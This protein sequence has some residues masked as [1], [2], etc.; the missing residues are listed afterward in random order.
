LN[1][2]KYIKWFVKEN[3]ITLEDGFPITCYR[4]DY[5]IDEDVFHEWA[6]HIRRHYESDDDLKESL[7]E[8]KMS[9]ENYLRSLVIPQ[10]SDLLG[11]TSRS[12]D[13]TEIMISDLIEFIHGY[14]VPRCKQYN[15]SGKTQS[16]HG[17]DILAYK[18]LNPDNIPSVK[19]ELLVI[20]VKSEL[21]SDKY[22]PIKDAVTISHK[23]DKIR[24]TH[25]LNYYRKKLRYLKKEKQA[26]EISRFQNK[27]EHDYLIT[28]IA[29][30]INS[31]ITIPENIIFGI[32]GDDLELRNND[33][34][35]LVHG[36]KLMD[37]AHAIYDRCIE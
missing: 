6:I 12:N 30:A 4:L 14:I 32:K 11:P 27:S 24:H 10:K 33:K 3:N 36:D 34:I 1:Q 13:F 25:T 2:P 5:K 17:S 18:I 15:R 21:S 9:T 19:D 23:Y 31:R 28:Y 16:E 35:F 26:N 20:E 8:T 22:T 7:K 29:S 37:L